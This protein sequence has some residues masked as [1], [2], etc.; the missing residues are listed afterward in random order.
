MS[1]TYFKVGI[2]RKGALLAED[3]P[4]SLLALHHSSS[5]EKVVLQLCHDAAARRLS[6]LKNNNYSNKNERLTTEHFTF[7]GVELTRVRKL[8][9][10]NF[11]GD[12]VLDV[13]KMNNGKLQIIRKMEQS[14]WKKDLRIVGALMSKTLLRQIRH[15]AY[16][17]LFIF[18]F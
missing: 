4:Q 9:N 14:G 12:D 7:I 1:I 6:N 11:G 13:K 10:G 3:S 5:L 15:P 17:P 16:D 18:R 8:S 2:L